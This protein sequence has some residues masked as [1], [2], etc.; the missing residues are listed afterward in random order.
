MTLQDASFRLKNYWLFNP[1]TY[2]L[3]TTY[4][5]P[6]LEQLR[7]DFIFQ[8]L[9]EEPEVS[10]LSSLTK[11]RKF[12][13]NFYDQCFY[14]LGKGMLEACGA[15]LTYLSLH[16][17][18]DW[19]V[20]APVHNVVAS[21]CP[22]LVTLL[23]SGDYKARHTL[24]ECDDQLDFAIPGPAHPNLL[25]LKVTGVVSDQRLRFLLSHGPALQTIHLDGELEWLH[26]S[27]L[28]AALQINPLPDLEEIWFNV[29][30]TV[31]LASV[32]LLLQQDNPLKC[33][34]RLCHM[35]EATMGEYQ[36]LLAH[37]RQHNLDIK[38]IWVTD[39]RIKK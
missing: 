12:E 10:V 19:F 27:T 34:G 1:I 13:I 38:L 7:L 2:D 22:N 25:H 4:L 23:Y 16:L 30:T 5:C 9:I 36:E 14:D 3:V 24:E 21:C 29:S 37:V 8:D 17:A 33:I 32:R 35:G 20:V 11:L 15:S 31:T 39:E 6:D 18:D 26:D 28:V